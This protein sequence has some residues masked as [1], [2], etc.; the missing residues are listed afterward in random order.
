MTPSEFFYTFHLG[1][2]KT[3]T[4]AAGDKAY[5]RQIENRYAGA[6]CLAIGSGGVY[7]QEQVRYLRGFVTITS[8]ED[9]T[10][11]DRVEPMLKEAADLLDVELVSSS[12]YFTDLQFLKD[13]GRSMVYDM[14]TCAALA[15]FPEPQMV[16]ISLIAE[17]LGVTEFGLLEKIRK[18]V[19]MEVELR[20]NRIKLLYPEGHDMLEPRYANLHKGN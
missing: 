19:E 16:A 12:S 9:T 5:V 11:V 6:I 7:T 17:E 13:A 1:Y 18:Q 2:T 14:Y 3:P 4:E 8:Q 15:D 10:L 20:K